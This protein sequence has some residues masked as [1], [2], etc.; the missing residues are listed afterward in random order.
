MKFKE[1][2]S[3]APAERSHNPQYLE[4]IRLVNS[5]FLERPRDITQADAGLRG[6]S[7]QHRGAQR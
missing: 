2:T 1:D 5:N 4:P 6:H 3:K 7:L